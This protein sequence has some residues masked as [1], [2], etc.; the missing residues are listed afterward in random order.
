MSVTREERQF[1]EDCIQDPAKG[2]GNSV[3]AEALSIS[4]SRNYCDNREETSDN[5]TGSLS[6]YE[7]ENT[8]A[9]LS[10]IP[11]A[12]GKPSNQN[13][14]IPLNR[15]KTR[16]MSPKLRKQR[17][18]VLFRF[19]L[20]NVTL[21]AFVLSVLS[22][23]WGAEYRES[24]FIHKVNILTVIQD[25][26]SSVSPTL[27]ENLP[28]I[29]EGL[30]CTWHIYNASEYQK[31]RKINATEIN[32]EVIRQIYREKYWMALN[33]KPNATDYF[34]S[35]LTNSSVEPFN[36]TKYFQV[37]YETGREPLNM[38]PTILPHMQSL[39]TLYQNYISTKYLPNM[40]SNINGSVVPKNIIGASKVNFDYMDYR[41]WTNPTVQ[42]PLQVGMIYCLILT[43]FQIGFY[44][45]LHKG[46]AQLLKPRSMIVYR[47]C[48]S[49]GTYFILSL[50]FCT[51]SAM[52]QVDFKAAFGRGGFVVYWMSTWLLMTALGG[53]NENV[54]SLAIAFCP[55]YMG[56]WLMFW[57]ISNIAPSFYPMVIHSSFYRYG[58]MM[59]IHNAL[60]IYKVIFLNTS[61]HTLGRNYGILCA[62]VGVNTSLFPFVMM[63]VGKKM[64]KVAKASAAAQK[65]RG[66]E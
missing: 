25:E 63:I 36:F 16:F 1:N 21:A 2:I 54:A 61:K 39:E 38:K 6:A 49:F 59:P 20:T 7:A 33:V 18:K 52:F 32:S 9:K 31:Q 34:Y 57:I 23:Y 60:D 17:K 5:H 24:H 10:S 41:P 35:S 42:S 22:I 47:I 8:M 53:A 45:P 3:R 48:I 12:N 37:V 30:P 14:I 46:M 40:L 58:Y 13:D 4:E 43:F 64:E 50:F 15:A 44:G 28:S 55:Q 26:S 51:I 19:V 56:C 66:K 29:I 27:V 62:W 65:E 11:I